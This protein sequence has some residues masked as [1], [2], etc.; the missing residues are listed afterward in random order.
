MITAQFSLDG[1]MATCLHQNRDVAVTPSAEIRHAAKTDRREARCCRAAR[2]PHNN[3]VVGLNLLVT[4]P[5]TV[6]RA[7]VVLTCDSKSAAG[8]DVSVNAASVC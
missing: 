2:V 4:L 7:L 5:L 6:Q 3:E 1:R 8:E